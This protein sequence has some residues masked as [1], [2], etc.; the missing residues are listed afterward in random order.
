MSFGLEVWNNINVKTLEV[1]SKTLMFVATREVEIYN[2]SY[3]YRD[4]VFDFR[5][6]GSFLVILS[7]RSGAR[8]SYNRMAITKDGGI[9]KVNS[10]NFGDTTHCFITVGIFL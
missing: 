10:G 5:S 7:I 4:D 9:L 8:S 3:K 6:L 1:N 2:A